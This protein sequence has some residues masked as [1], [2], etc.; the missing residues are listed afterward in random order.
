MIMPAVESGEWPRLSADQVERIATEAARLY[1][2]SRRSRVN[3]FV[4][5]VFGM[6]LI[7][8]V[9]GWKLCTTI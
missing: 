6:R 2:E 5:L 9:A 8:C 4:G 3:A 7:S 1:F